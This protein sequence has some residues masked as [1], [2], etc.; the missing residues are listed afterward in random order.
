MQ[1][2][3]L[4]E[5]WNLEIIFI[6][7]SSS[8]NVVQWTFFSETV[9]AGFSLPGKVPQTLETSELSLNSDGWLDKSSSA[10]HFTAVQLQYVALQ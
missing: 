8:K 2:I 10:T 9:E 3:F 7:F 1:D 5:T 6:F 4:L